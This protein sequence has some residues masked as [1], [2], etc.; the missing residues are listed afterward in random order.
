MYRASGSQHR[1]EKDVVQSE[2]SSSTYASVNSQLANLDQPQTYERSH[3]LSVGYAGTKYQLLVFMD[4]LITLISQ[5]NDFDAKVE[6][7]NR[8]NLDDIGIAIKENGSVIAVKI[9]QVKHYKDPITMAA[10]YNKEK[11]GA[12]EERKEKQSNEKMHIGKFFD[13]WL[14]Y[15]KE[16][17]HL[18]DEQIQP[19][20]Y[21]NTE[22]DTQLNSWIE[23]KRFKNTFI[24]EVE[25][26]AVS[27]SKKK[28]TLVCYNFLKDL[29]SAPQSKNVWIMLHERG[30]IDKDRHL[31]DKF[32]PNLPNFTLGL[33]EN[34]LPNGLTS[35][36]I[37]EKLTKLYNLQHSDLIS[38]YTVLHDQGWAYLQKN[39]LHSD[40]C[41]LTATE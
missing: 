35:K 40:K 15:K 19:I 39:N 12:N 23:N 37:L 28:P 32:T 36:L 3:L 18:S 27:K 10:F 33:E 25:K 5:Q 22:L 16:Y 31:T 2:P 6:E 13:G 4:N 41:N 30:F 20:L 11:E 21:T 26:A 24:Q 7:K 29:V 1:D 34:K 17:P 38:F 8:G 14:A 9:Y